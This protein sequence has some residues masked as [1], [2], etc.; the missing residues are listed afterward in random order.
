[1]NGSGGALASAPLVGPSGGPLLEF[2]GPAR[3]VGMSGWSTR[4]HYKKLKHV[5]DVDTGSLARLP[6]LQDLNN[7]AGTG[8][9][10][11]HNF[12]IGMFY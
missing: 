2:T 5:E 3:D 8:H 6:G 10:Q 1:M 9:Q 12:A 11:S 7:L 4:E